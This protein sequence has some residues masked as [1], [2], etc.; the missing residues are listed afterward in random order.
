MIEYY[1]GIQSDYVIVGL[2]GVVAFLF[3][4]IIIILVKQH[5]LK[6]AYKN[7]MKG[8]DGKSLEET[9]I[10]QLGQVDNLIESNA[11]NERDLDT[12]QR[13]SR[14]GFRKI[15]LVKY[16]ALQEM[17]GKLSFTLCLLSDQNNGFV[18][19]VV[20]SREG[21]YSYIKEIIDGNSIGTLAEE[22]QQALSK[23]LA[24]DW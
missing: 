9:L 7:F 19:N 16:D 20:H 12:L 15:G 18:L 13:K 23:A 6:K 14:E 22:E 8:N 24:E 10:D 2:A 3:L 17:G 11:S 4:L 1:L 5:N 21:C